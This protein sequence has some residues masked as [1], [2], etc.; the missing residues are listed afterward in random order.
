M[1]KTKNDLSEATRVKV[2]ELL[3]TRL[4]EM[5]AHGAVSPTAMALWMFGGQPTRSGNRHKLHK[6]KRR[7]PRQQPTCRSCWKSLDRMPYLAI[8]NPSNKCNCE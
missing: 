2:I 6:T 1:F 3:N 4:A 8:W 5:E 7:S